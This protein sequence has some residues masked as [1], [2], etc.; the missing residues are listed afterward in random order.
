MESTTTLKITD[1]ILLDKIKELPL[2]ELGKD[3]QSRFDEMEFYLDEYYT[4]TF[5]LE[6]FIYWDDLNERYQIDQSYISNL[7]L[8][9]SPSMYRVVLTDDQEG[10][11]KSR[12]RNNLIIE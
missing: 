3:R 8:F 6:T 12:V 11:I 7:K 10:I 9:F 4:L 5:I 1:K 2:I